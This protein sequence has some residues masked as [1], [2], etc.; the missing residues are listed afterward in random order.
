MLQLEI[1]AFSLIEMIKWNPSISNVTSEIGKHMGP[2]K[3]IFNVALMTHN[4]EL[5]ILCKML[6][7]A[8]AQPDSAD[9]VMS[10]VIGAHHL[11]NDNVMLILLTLIMFI[12]YFPHSH[13]YSH[14]RHHPNHLGSLYHKTALCRLPCSPTNPSSL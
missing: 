12:F 7:G 9:C 13:P 2:E 8:W 14:H 4:L 6:S 3:L 10:R 1:N 11:T 5:M